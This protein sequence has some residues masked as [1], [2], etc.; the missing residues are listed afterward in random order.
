MASTRT[1]L[2]D[3][4]D[5]TADRDAARAVLWVL[6]AIACWWFGTSWLALVLCGLLAAWFTASSIRH[7]RAG[8]KLRASEE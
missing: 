1:A 7:T 2:L 4:F 8:N 5:K 6:I 3:Y